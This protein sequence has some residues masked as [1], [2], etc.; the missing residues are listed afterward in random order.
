VYSYRAA[1]DDNGYLAVYAGTSPE[2]IHESLDVVNEQL[3]RLV[4]EG[5]PADELDAAKGHLTGSLTMSLET[6]ASRM[7][8]IG[9]AEQV[10]GEVPTLDELVARVERVTTADVDRVIDRV[11][12]DADRTMAV[13]GPHE[14]SDF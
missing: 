5:L 6:S 12:R 2:R 14:P 9:R 10:E 7:R 13:V 3:D 8:R 11:L 4:R 1:F